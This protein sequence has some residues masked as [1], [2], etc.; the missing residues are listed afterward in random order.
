MTKAMRISDVNMVFRRYIFSGRRS[1]S[2]Y[3]V[4]DLLDVQERAVLESWDFCFILDEVP[5]VPE[6]GVD[7]GT[8]PQPLLGTPGIVHCLGSEVPSCPD[9]PFFQWADILAGKPQAQAGASPK[10]QPQD[11][12]LH[13]LKALRLAPVQ[14]WVEG[15][16][17]GLQ[18]G[19]EKDAVEPVQGPT[20]QTCL[21]E[22]DQ[23]PEASLEPLPQCARE[24]QGSIPGCSPGAWWS[25]KIGSPCPSLWPRPLCCIRCLVKPQQPVFSCSSHSCRSPQPCW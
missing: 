17:V 13:L 21:V 6:S 11:L 18:D 9:S 10:A 5:P 1:F 7:R 4:G 3:V 20:F 2:H 24:F 16:W 19:A 14:H 22:V 25:P 12:S 15:D 23:L 8:G